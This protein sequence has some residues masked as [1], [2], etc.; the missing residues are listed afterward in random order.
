MTFISNLS[1]WPPLLPAPPYAINWALKAVTAPVVEPISV[2][3]AKAHARIE[4]TD[5]DTGPILRFIRTCRRQVERDTNRYYCT[6]TWN[7]LIDS[8][9]LRSIPIII[10]RPPLQSVLSIVTTDTDEVATTMDPTGYLVDTAS[11]PGRV[12]LIDNAIWPQDLRAFQPI[13]V[14]FVAGY[15]GLQHGG[16]LTAMTWANNT[17]SVTSTMPHDFATGDF[18]V[19]SGVTPAGYNGTY[20]V[21]VVNSFQFT[22]TLTSNPGVVT[23]P[24]IVSDLGV[25]DEA[26]QAM[27]LLFGHF[28]ENREASIV[29]DR[30]I[31]VEDMPFGYDDLIA[32]LRIHAVG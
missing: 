18:G 15:T 22:Y 30:R 27:L 7:L 2:T 13:T 21:A 1:P 10:P 17:V 4:I 9:P 8:F 6:Q 25:P 14:Q 28:Y 3:M 11:E 19:L 26:V 16:V 5:D 32:T 12:G 23:T 31:T 24:G 20:E 29:S